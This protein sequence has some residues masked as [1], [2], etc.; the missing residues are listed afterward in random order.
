MIGE[1]VVV[2]AITLQLR[3]I[4]SSA[5]T[6]LSSLQ[7]IRILLVVGVADIIVHNIIEL[8]SSAERMS[9]KPYVN[10]Y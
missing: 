8:F 5:T 4:V 10:L 3:L 9:Q 7:L 2:N 6:N 1:S